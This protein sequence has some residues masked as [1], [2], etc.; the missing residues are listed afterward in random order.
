MNYAGFWHRVVASML[1]VIIVSV[2]SIPTLFLNEV[3]QL[4][5]QILIAFT[6][7]T[8]LTSSKRQG[9]FGK[10]ILGLKVCNLDGTRISYGKSVAR[11]FGKF[12]ST[13]T[14][15]LGYLMVAF[16][17]RKQGLHDRIV[18]TVVSR[19]D[20]ETQEEGTSDPKPIPGNKTTGNDVVY[21]GGGWV[22]G[23]FD[24]LGHISRFYFAFTDRD[25]GHQDKG[26]TVGR[27]AEGNDLVIS[28]SSVSRFHARFSS[29]NG[30]L[31]LEDLGS[32]NGTFVGSVRLTPRV[33]T[34]VYGQEELRFGDAVFSIGRDY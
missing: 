34:P 12:L 18:E 27:E 6:Y 7:E 8:Y 10:S 25:E 23:G 14:L 19:S 1:D 20:S 4:V 2:L 24:E 21:Q 22:L 33:A 5:A 32:K 31:F 16:T 15:F 29:K 11:Y 17:E 13:L 28:N 26:V 30:V 9:T 3:Y